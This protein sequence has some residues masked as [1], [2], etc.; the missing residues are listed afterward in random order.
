MAEA[1]LDEGLGYL[2]AFITD[3]TAKHG[4]IEG[5]DH[6]ISDFQ[7]TIDQLHQ[8]LE[9]AKSK[10]T[11]VT[12]EKEH[13]LEAAMQSANEAVQ[14]LVDEGHQTLQKLA[15][16][17]EHT[18]QE[19]QDQITSKAEEVVNRLSHGAQDLMDQGYHVADEAV[20][21]VTSKVNDLRTHAESAYNDL[22]GKVNDLQNHAHETATN[23]MNQIQDAGQHVVG[24]LSQTA[25]SLFDNFHQVSDQ[26]TGDDGLLGHF[27]HLTES[28]EHGFGQMGDMMSHLGDT[29]VQQGEQIIT[30][31]IQFVEQEVMQRL[32]Q[33]FEK[34]IVDAVEALIEDFVESIAMMTL[35]SAITA[36]VSPF[37]PEIAAAKTAVT[38][39]N[40]L[41]DA[42]N[43]FD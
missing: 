25:T 8:H 11:Q 19:K 6:Q 41:L 20:H 7:S 10:L 5:I 33:E 29:L 13:A 4:D 42:L 37:V 34:I 16:V 21:T 26:L 17:V 38:A 23:V 14:H 43:P 15:D 40:D 9:E 28:A 39:I 31:T 35:G 3:L 30:D 22:H 36:A 12:E 1:Q 32:A 24:D 27:N 18:I 2:Q